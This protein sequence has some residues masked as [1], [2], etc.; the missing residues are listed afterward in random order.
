VPGVA[1]RARSAAVP[2]VSWSSALSGTSG[3]TPLSRRPPPE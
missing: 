3:V 2:S 1:S